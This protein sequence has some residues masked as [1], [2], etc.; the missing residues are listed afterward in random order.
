[1]QSTL[2]LTLDLDT[3]IGTLTDVT[4]YSSLGLNPVNFGVKAYGLIKFNG[5]TIQG[6]GTNWFNPLIDLEAGNT[7]YQFDLELDVN[8]EVA[9]GIY[10]V[11]GYQIEARYQKQASSGFSGIIIDAQGYN[12]TLYSTPSD[13]YLLVTGIGTYNYGSIASVVDLGGGDVMFTPSVPY[14]SVA[15]SLRDIVL[16]FRT[17]SQTYVYSGC[18]K[19]TQDIEF[20]YDCDTD[21]TGSWSVYS[22]TP[23]PSGVNVSAATGTIEWPSWTGEPTITVASLPYSNTAL[24][25]G[26]YGATITQIVTQEIQ[27]SPLLEVGYTLE[28]TYE[29]KVTCAGSLCEMNACIESLRAAHETELLRNKVSKYQPYID[30]VAIY[31]HEADNYKSCAQFDKYR[32]TLAKVK[33]TLDASGCDCGCC[34][35]NEYK[36]VAVSP[37][38]STFLNNLMSEIQFRVGTTANRPSSIN[39]ASGNGLKVGAIY[40]STTDNNLYQISSINLNGAITWVQYYDPTITSITTATN[41]LTESPAGTVIL[42]GGLTSSTTIS[43][44]NFPLTIESVNAV[45]YIKK[46]GSSNN[47]AYP[48]VISA[49]SSGT[50]NGAGAGF[51][52]ATQDQN[53]PDIQSSRILS[54]WTAYST[55]SQLIF[56]VKNNNAFFDGFKISGSDKSLT[57]KGYGLGNLINNNPEYFLGVDTNGN[58]VEIDPVNVGATASNGLTKTSG[59]IKLGGALTEALTTITTS[60]SNRLAISGLQSG[61]ATKFLAI[62]SQN[63]VINASP[64]GGSDRILVARINQSGT[65]DPT[66]TDIYNDV[67]LTTT[68]KRNGAG[69]YEIT[70]IGVLNP[71]SAWITFTPVAIEPP[72]A[73]PIA[74]QITVNYSGGKFYVRSYRMTGTPTISLYDCIDNALMR[75]ELF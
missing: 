32:E 68:W 5:T 30:N 21:P 72:L 15:Q 63:R 42:G 73:S 39:V 60:A 14:P 65:N 75:V 53:S 58:F 24:A 6:S 54:S 4:N 27:A 18:N 66:Q 46:D 62:D 61:T 57:A 13:I 67:G 38:T 11:E 44:G 45:T 8:G 16:K 56:S 9:N 35:D 49:Q 71:S 23:T 69:D 10:S 22:N 2:T 40:H 48:L 17:A 19:I 41:G 7:T 64:V 29:W 37:A 34:D 43:L 26:T 52:F 31:L 47:I 50:T 3:K 1:M 33:A 25:T 70:L 51:Y 55:E 59:D 20:S 12:A 36:W 74:T 28:S